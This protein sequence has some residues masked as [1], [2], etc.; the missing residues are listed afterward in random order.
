MAIPTDVT[1]AMFFMMGILGEATALVALTMW[2]GAPVHCLRTIDQLR[3]PEAV[4]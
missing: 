1:T 2:V 3:R 4:L